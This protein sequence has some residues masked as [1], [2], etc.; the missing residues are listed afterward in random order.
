MLCYIFDIANSWHTS[1]RF[2]LGR[3]ATVYF[4]AA[5]VA[6]EETGFRLSFFE[7]QLRAR[8]Y[9]IKDFDDLIAPFRR[10]G[11]TARLGNDMPA[12]VE[13]GGDNCLA[14]AAIE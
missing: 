13:G 10:K 7:Q 5:S 2:D 8:D 11:T 6:Q 12:L 9:C 14:A 4:L 3:S 1:L